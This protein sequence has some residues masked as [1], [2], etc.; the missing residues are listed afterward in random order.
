MISENK[1]KLK[2]YLFLIS[3]FFSLLIWAHILYIYLYYD[4]TEKPVEW[5]VVSEWIIWDFPHLNPLLNSTDYNKNIISLLYRGLMKYN[6]E[7]NKLESDLANC[8]IEDLSKIVCYLKV[9]QKWSNWK[10][11][12]IKDVV[13]TYNILKNSNTNSFASNILKQTTIEYEE[14]VIKFFNNVKDINFLSILTQWIVSKDILDNIWNK[15]LYWKFN[16]IDWIFSWPYIIDTISFDDSSWIKK[17]IL[18]KN[19]YFKEKNILVSKYVFKFFKDQNHL[20]KHIN[21]IS[22]FLDNQKN[23]SENNPRLEKKIYYLNQFASLFINE[24]RLKNKDLRGFI[25]DNINVD[26]ILNLLPKWFKK[27]DYLFETD[28]KN[29]NKTEINYNLEDILRQLWYY[30]KENLLENIEK[31][32]SENK[33]NEEN[34]ISKEKSKI[35]LS[36]FD[37]KYNFT[38]KDNI[39]I[40]WKVYDNVINVYINDYKLTKFKQ[41]NEKFYFKLRESFK[42]IAPWKNTYKIYFETK[43]GKELIDEFYVFYDKD[44]DKLD[45]LKENLRKELE[46]KENEEN[47]KEL[48]LKEK[49]EIQE[50]IK[51]LEDNFFYNDKYEKFSLKLYYIEDIKE[52]KIVANNIKK[53][54]EMFWINVNIL[55]ISLEELNNK[56]LDGNKD[57]DMIIAGIDSWFFDFNMYP[58]FHSSESKNWYNLA[59]IRDLNLDLVLEELRTQILTKEKIT[60]LKQKIIDILEKRK[61]IKTLYKKNNILYID[62]NIKNF[63]LKENFS[64]NLFIHQK[65]LD[66]YINTQKNISIE[67]KWFKDFISFI[68]KILKNEWKWEK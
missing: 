42:N 8:E 51:L 23:L 28:K 31:I 48:S 25:I 6:Y 22:L 9:G 58:Y 7:E 46:K 11:I 21:N 35:L 67:N 56:I 3:M 20:S 53:Q 17:L 49:N 19:P 52:F 5:W 63:N 61:S 1:N 62:K 64:S 39:L 55:P 12:K 13:S 10:D 40:E 68:F 65:I 54:I 2:K 36:P 16:P 57:Y 15:E 26:N 45:S 59:N 44:K 66:S 41:W 50:K 27:I 24:D 37:L 32:N 14:W 4:S 29:W 47:K 30:K 43:N 18:I 38:Q 34:L 60:E 33:F